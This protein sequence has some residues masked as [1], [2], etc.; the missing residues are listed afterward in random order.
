MDSRAREPIAIVGSG[1]RFPGGASSPARLWELLRQ[2]RDVSSHI[3]EDRF[4]WQ[5]FYHPDGAHH[6][7][8][9][10]TRGYF[11]EEGIRNFDAKFFNIPPAEA[12]SI[13]PQQRLLLETVYEAIESAGMSL[14]A[15]QGTQTA[16][17]VG[18][19]A[20]D[21]QDVM[22]ADT[23]CTPTYTGTGSARSI[24]SNRISY[25]FDWH[26]PSMTIDTACSSSMMAIHLGVQAL[27][28]GDA[29]VA[30][31]AG[32]SLMIGSEIFTVLSNLSMLSPDGRSKMW[33]ADANGYARGEAVGA[34]VLKP[35]SAA[36]RDGDPVE[37]VIREV[38]VNQD[39]RTK[40]ITMPSEVA[41]AALIRQTYRRAGLDPTKASDRPQYFEAHGTGTPAG[42]PREAEA[43]TQAFF[44]A[45]SDPSGDNPLYVGSIKTIV[46]HTEGTAGIAGVLKA[47]LALQNGSIS[48]NMLLNRL[49]ASVAPFTKNLKVPTSLTPWPTVPGNAPRRASVNSFGFGGANGHAIL[50]S[51]VPPRTVEHNP[52]GSIS[53]SPFTFSA[54]SEPNLKSTLERFV[55][56]LH[57]FPETNIRD[58]AY[59]LQARRSVF[60]FRTSF[61]STT[62]IGLHKAITQKLE[63]NQDK[64]GPGLGVLALSKPSKKI[65][66]VFTGQGAQWAGMGKE[67]ITQIPY[68][69]TLLG[70]LEHSLNSL[71][72]ADK[73]SWSLR[74]QLLAGPESSRL[75]EAAIAQPLCTAVQVILV[76]LLQQAG[77]NFTAVVGHSSGEIGAAYAAG[78]LSASDA[79]RVAYYR[80][81]FAYLAEGPNHEK[82]AML[83][84]GASLED[85]QALCR[86]ADYEGRIT[87][88]ASN[89]PA[90]VTL[91][92]DID[93]INCAKLQFDEEKTFARLL[94]VDTA[95]HSHHM[96]PT[97]GPYVQ[98]LQKCG[99]EPLTPE[100]G[101]PHWYS[102]VKP[103]SEAMRLG[104]ELGGEYWR[105]NMTRAVLFSQAIENA[106][107]CAG[108]FDVAVEVGPHPALRGPFL[109]TLDALTGKK[110][111]YS[112]CLAR[113]TNDVKAFSDALGFF[114][115][116]L[117]P[118]V[119]NLDAYERK[120]APDSPKRTF[121][122]GLPS[123][124]WTYERPYWYE[125]R[126]ARQR[127]YRERP[128]HPLLGIAAGDATESEYRWR[129]YLR[130]KE[131]PWLDHHRLQGQPVLPAAGYVC[132][133]W[134]A[135]L[136]VSDGRPV[137]LFELHNFEI[138]HGL[139]FDDNPAGR[140]IIFTLFNIKRFSGNP[141]TL[142]ARFSCH[143]VGSRESNQLFVNAGGEITVTYGA[144]SASI[145]PS[146]PQQLTNLVDT[147]PDAFYD[148]LARLGYG[149]EDE[150]RSIASLQRKLWHSRGVLRR[151]PHS[152]L[153]VHPATL[154]VAFQVPVAATTYPGDGVLWTLHAPVMVRHISFNPYF[155]NVKE[156]DEEWVFESTFANKYSM[157]R[158]A[159]VQIYP[160][161]SSNAVFQLEGIEG[162][163]L[164]PMTAA[165]DRKLFS[166]NT[167]HQLS[168]NGDWAADGHRA[169]AKEYEL[170]Y[171]L[172]RVAYYYLRQ[173]HQNVSA[174][175]R[176]SAQTH[177]QHLLAFAGL[178][179]EQVASGQHVWVKPEWVADTKED[180]IEAAVEHADSIDLR[181][182]HS[183]GENVL[184]VVRGETTMQDNML[185]DYY[186]SALGYPVMNKWLARMVS[187]LVH[188]FPRMKILEIGASTGAT[189]EILHSTGLKFISYTCTDISPAVLGRAEMELQE[190]ASKIEYRTLDLEADFVEQGFGAQGYDLVI[191]SNA[192]HATKSLHKTLS[193]VRGLLRPGGYLVLSEIT[194]NSPTRFGFVLGGL[195]EW[196]VGHEDGRP[197]APTI[198][199]AEWDGVL[200][201][202][203][204]S[205]VDA[206]TPADD[207]LPYPLSIMAAQ[208][209]DSRIEALREPLF[210]PHPIVGST[211]NLGELLIVGGSGL[212]ASKL[213]QSISRII[214]ARFTKVVSV[215]S[216]EA[217]SQLSI[218]I[219]PNMIFLG[220]LD[221]PTFK[222]MTESKLKSL[223]ALIKAARSILWLTF[224]TR[225]S[226][227]Y[228]SMSI[229]FGR[230]V[231]HETPEMQ[232]QFLDINKPGHVNGLYVAE[233]L[234]RLCAVTNLAKSGQMEEMLWSS[235]PEIYLQDGK[236]YIPRVMH[237][238]T[239]NDRYN[240]RQRTVTH[241]VDSSSSSV[242]LEVLR[243][244]YMLKEK[245]SKAL[246]EA[247]MADFVTI[248]VLAST[249]AA[250][251]LP[252]IG[253]TFIAY[254][255]V[256]GTTDTVMVS[257][258][259]NA[260]ILQVPQKHLVAC[261]DRTAA[262]D[263]ILDTVVWEFTAERLLGEAFH[264]GTILLYQAPAG[265]TSALKRR[266]SD[267]QVNV[268]EILHTAATAPNQIHMHPRIMA[269]HIPAL[270]PQRVS[271]LANFSLD[272]GPGSFVSRLQASLIPGCKVISLNDMFSPVVEIPWSTAA[273]AD[274]LHS[275]L[276]CAATTAMEV[277]STNP[278][279]PD[280]KV[281]SVEE[282]LAQVPGST[283][284]WIVNWEA[285]HSLSVQ[286][287]P[288]TAQV[289]FRGDKTYLLIGLTADLGQSLCEW[290]IS[291]GART[292]VLVSRNP[293]VEQIWLDAQQ[294]DGGQVHVLSADVTKQQSVHQMYQKIVTELPP[295]AGVVNAAMV[296]QDSIFANTSIDMLNKVLSPKVDGSRYLNELFSEPNLDFF[297]LFSSL[298]VVGGNSGQTSYTAANAYLTALAGQRRS[299][300]LAASVMDLGAVLGLGYVTRSGTFTGDDIDAF[301]GYPIAESD[302][303]EHFAEAVLAS[304]VGED[305]N[306][307]IIS[308]VREVDPILDDRV[309]W[310][311]NPR[312]SHL[313]VDKEA[314]IAGGHDDK[315]SLPLKEQLRDAKT[316]QET[317]KII[318]DA[319]TDRLLV[320]LQ[321]P[322]D[323]LAIP[324]PLVELGVDSLVAVEI[325]SWFMKKLSVEVPVL[326]VLGGSTM[327]DLVDHA[328]QQLPQE[329]LPCQAAEEPAAEPN[330][331]AKDANDPPETSGPVVESDATIPTD[332]SSDADDTEQTGSDKDIHP[333]PP[334]S[335]SLDGEEPSYEHVIQK[336]GRMS[337][338]QA[339][340]WFLR[341]HLEDPTTWNVTFCHRI[342]GGLDPQEMNQAMVSL[343]KSHEGLR[344]CFFDGGPDGTQ[345][346]QGV[347]A[348]SRLKLEFRQINH[349]DEVD[350]EFARLQSYVYDLQH[351]DTMRAVLLRKSAQVHYLII[352]YHHIA[353]DGLGFAGFLQELVQVSGGL[354]L[355][356]IKH[357]N[358]DYA[359]EQ[360]E[361]YESGQMTRELDYW[362]KELKSP[363]QALPLL[364]FAHVSYRQP[365]RVH[366]HHFADFRISPVLTARIKRR[367]RN[368][369]VTSFHFYLTILQTLIFKLA[370]V[371]DLCIGIADSGRR[372]QDMLRTMGVFLN[373]LPV[374]FTRDLNQ[375]FG[376]AVRNSR[377][378][379]YGAL[380]H[381]SVPL[382]VILEQL[383]IPR[384]TEAAPLFQVFFDFRQ[385]VQERMV[386]GG[387][388]V[389]RTHWD[390]GRTAYDITLDIMENSDSDTVVSLATQQS[391][392]SQ[393]DTE[394]LSRMFQTLIEDFAT[395]PAQRLSEALL[396]TK[397]DVNKAIEI[398]RGPQMR[399]CWPET[400][401]A[402]I[403]R[404]AAQAPDLVALV[405]GGIDSVDITYRELSNRATCIA[406]ALHGLKVGDRVV[407]AQEPGFDQ[408]SAIL[409][410]FRLG[411]VYVPVDTRQPIQRLRDVVEDCQATI[412]LCHTKTIELADSL[413]SGKTPILNTSSIEQKQQMMIEPRSV[414]PKSPAMILYTSGSTGKPKGT[415]LSHGN[416]C[417]HLEAMATTLKVEKDIILQQT[418]FTFDLA[419]SQTLICLCTGSTLVIVPQPQRSDV[420][421][422]TSLISQKNVTFT[423]A[424]PSEYAVWL[425]FG[426]NLQS[427]NK[428]RLAVSGGELL[429]PALV[430]EF[431]TVLKHAPQVINSY[432]PS[433]VTIGSHCTP[434]NSPSNG[435]AFP[436]GK[437]LPN[438]TT[439][440]MDENLNPLPVGYPGEICIGGC[441]VT[442]GY[443]NNQD[444]TR[445]KYAS[446]SFASEYTLSRGW[447]Q[448]QRTG[449]RGR[450]TSDGSLHFHGRMGNDTIVK[451]RGIRVE[452]EDIENVILRQA[453]GVLDQAVVSVRGDPAFLI[454]H[455]VFSQNGASTNHDLFL[456]DLLSSLPVPQYMR[457][458]MLIALDGLPLTPHSKTDRRAIAK[459]PLPATSQVFSGDRAYLTQ[460]EKALKAV[461]NEILPSELIDLTASRPD[462]TFFDAGGNSL[463]LIKLQDLIRR[464]FSA[465]LSLVD[466][467]EA[468]TLELM[469]KRIETATRAARLDWA[470]ETSIGDISLPSMPPKAGAV[471]ASSLV[472][473]MTG[474]TGALGSRVLTQL[475]S[476]SRV[477]HIHC[478]AVRGNS[479]KRQD[480]SKVSYHAGDLSQPYLGLATEKFEEL[481]AN[482]D[483]VLHIGANRSFWDNYQVTRQ[484]NVN[485]TKAL[486]ALAAPRK[487]P[488][489]YISSGGVFF[490][491]P[492]PMT[493]QGSKLPESRC[494]SSPPSDGS[495]GYL[496]SKWVSEKILEN[497]AEKIHLPVTI[498]RPMPVQSPSAS[499]SNH[500]QALTELR[501]ITQAQG[502]NNVSSGVKGHFDLIKADDLATAVSSAIF[503]ETIASPS[504]SPAVSYVH[505]PGSVRL[506]TDDLASV[507]DQVA[508]PA[509]EKE[510][511]SGPEWI[512]LVKAA[513]F[514]YL[515][516]SQEF[517]FIGETADGE[518]EK[519][520]LLSR[521]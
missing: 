237:D 177:H 445:S 485:S 190:F 388:Q 273:D 360:H 246:A 310:I 465:V 504:S 180:L 146:S 128:F 362:R 463:L 514:S 444:L 159:T 520:P 369:H 229:G 291:Q 475:L 23:E 149:F 278:S 182:M 197:W 483:A 65:L 406:S 222:S 214:S 497:A 335:P 183:V 469:A 203:G 425:R 343:G 419:M 52:L 333:T 298:S 235:E 166:K 201:K 184:P 199:T 480:S 133:A 389:Q 404:H 403:D 261:G 89:S 363:P 76:S 471:R 126:A 440:I 258:A 38:G 272:G 366:R 392:Y 249:L 375:T 495:D 181:M 379:A 238:Q 512:G 282:C 415:V 324:V 66:G 98:S 171:L 260:S 351:G 26:G 467:Y 355:P 413:S 484:P 358:I 59:T 314:Q 79:I 236:E 479:K 439:Y 487:A 505:H 247:D 69:Q 281:A 63:D 67:L 93:A 27:R 155:A 57:R 452:L 12:D 188:R 259:F 187:Q 285:S 121:I 85:A 103:S 148:A 402:C 127:R 382:S 204:F 288:A 34:I 447:T 267:K 378:K 186:R 123:Y 482:V 312:M 205:G 213:V 433:E 448:I 436:V 507:W 418:A 191:A 356:P 108:P 243:D 78:F 173:L 437:A 456:K 129:N 438:Y 458:A 48:P 83:A 251:N 287:Q 320:I 502:L 377:T 384:S 429:T 326:K 309:P 84:V 115:T 441:G 462:I 517:Q 101:R 331:T 354:R 189:K 401:D 329:A 55:E 422:I 400:V 271:L 328:I 275:S 71:P 398:G 25:F 472:V 113:G 13:D 242:Q 130:P 394:L 37:C 257:T 39:G 283:A 478:V 397:E 223:K 391:L 132:M 301:G 330:T 234:L 286:V 506:G 365:L 134:E 228:N 319:L 315:K 290:M 470:E 370:D 21:Y 17:Y 54:P 346:M 255:V 303:R 11:L 380:E 73:P 168:L 299:Q 342:E 325:R 510:K 138:G 250:V 5:G 1:C 152:E 300:G 308:G 161:G 29:P 49:S 269:H 393:E 172:E 18:M 96:L 7:T 124:P 45:G 43:I 117:G 453:G 72:G 10:A 198:S 226:E 94:R 345:P 265:L 318:L 232:L 341:H 16:V 427:C 114:W 276:K 302:L 407:I 70:E 36:L 9:N 513:G 454:A 19:M 233:T 348:Q 218:P 252:S 35:L 227:P 4:S 521:R 361:A 516:V 263:Q 157:H 490:V 2:P 178:L 489:H 87:V 424:T 368:Y 47:S 305:S 158:E 162:K 82:G 219:P 41:Q 8:T 359:A 455:V 231:M 372:D 150:F 493:S 473:I 44:G 104:K 239:L 209:V 153:L 295:V 125:T 432:G 97:A 141:D 147:D 88:A 212:Q 245:P 349:E 367:C 270:L 154:D 215:N 316:I 277:L 353:M 416:F 323:G 460:A 336:E 386:L 95:Y 28:N 170:A 332:P 499:T 350:A 376:E 373:S 145:L 337:F 256:K 119:V 417:H 307:E 169:S 105:D 51:F 77:I 241:Q 107:D 33:D 262:R 221:Q 116:Y 165:D 90:S 224:G 352:G 518:D 15:L 179:V 434:V 240:T 459:L 122:R 194:D 503:G 430:D 511:I 431:R 509:E 176:E 327:P 207:P 220:D 322:S 112:G 136:E 411:A 167:F 92:G 496:A 486:V 217:V 491:E 99:I 339:Q 110:L 174:R 399:S 500:L 193:R 80:G 32:A 81:L 60:P 185:E 74:E 14:D 244:S 519:S 131:I 42:D 106:I 387:C 296:M 206:V 428:W 210:H 53:L 408:I 268:I 211:G 248:E 364:P 75:N 62:T 297:I 311:N 450:L 202:A 30:V 163:P 338:S 102:S 449:D 317:H 383:Q 64:N 304:P 216:L 412:I 143:S 357:Q 515:I 293:R 230:S 118:A 192:I 446:D 142:C 266:T 347:L 68:A 175:E 464:R 488:V 61:S 40:G 46:G 151:T 144:P 24:A 280:I 468:Q 6:G 137:Q 56:H 195:P 160:R 390:Y 344:T 31:A 474:A 279:L 405:D 294:K 86:N 381:G 457:P 306:H 200:R 371:D 140:E 334:S 100:S 451:L 461:W 414:S 58:L 477:S 395:S 508:K 22:L 292:V 498:H 274:K 340:F 423:F 492:T 321:L 111:P 501:D 139:M 208:A 476:D 385:G 156:A 225:G 466:I 50:E 442:L 409:A 253:P 396:F 420:V 494:D 109:Q 374:R 91:S 435:R 164:S 481:S 196:W 264:S 20:C 443:L 426:E 313:V 421:A 410:T 135:A 284:G 3:P 254:G 120:V 289:T